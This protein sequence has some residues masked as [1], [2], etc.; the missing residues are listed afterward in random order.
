MDFYFSSD[1]LKTRSGEKA[2]R[3][4]ITYCVEAVQ[5]PWKNVVIIC[6]G[7]DRSTGDSYGPLT[8]RLLMRRSFTVP[9][10]GTLDHP[11]HALTLEQIMSGIDDENTLVI[12]VDAQL[13][14]PKTVGG[15][16]VRNGPLKPGSALGKDL[17]YVGD[18]AIVGTVAEMSIAP[19]LM[20]QNAP[21]GL[22]FQMAELTARSIRFVI[23]KVEPYQDVRREAAP[24]LT[25]RMR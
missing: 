5:K 22:V 16:G 18:V 15:I 21:L 1:R 20:L 9:V 23:K 4:A 11:A 2:L 8:G 19:F 6:I 7:T 25:A 13:G 17:P 12:A 14:S 10:F 24:T 3:R